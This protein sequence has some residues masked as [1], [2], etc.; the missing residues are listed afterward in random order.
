[1]KIE[2]TVVRG[3]VDV[4]NFDDEFMPKLEAF[5]EKE[6][7]DGVEWKRSEYRALIEHLREL[8][9][10][11]GRIL[12]EETEDTYQVVLNVRGKVNNSPGWRL[13]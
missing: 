8:R 12:P 10:C 11:L 9:H 6:A 7:D 3:A 5:V 13:Y 1:V 2:I 4:I